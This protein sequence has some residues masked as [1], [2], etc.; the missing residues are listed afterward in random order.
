MNMPTHY[1]K[2]LRLSKS[3][4]EERDIERRKN[5][6]NSDDFFNLAPNPVEVDLQDVFKDIYECLDDE[7][8][9]EFS[10]EEREI[11]R[12]EAARMLEISD[13]RK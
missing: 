2:A 12:Q 5:K 7:D 9:E 10:A 1:F 8:D 3:T 6:K 13:P 11:I 4:G